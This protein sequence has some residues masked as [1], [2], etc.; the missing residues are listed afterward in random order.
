MIDLTTLITL[1]LMVIG[2]MLILIPA[3]PVSALQWTI[4][5]I[6]AALTGFQ[7]VTPAAALL[8]SLF[9]ILGATSGLWLPF[10]GLKGRNLSCLGLLAFFIGT[11]AGSFF[12]PIPILGALI[13][14]VAG[15]MMVEYAQILE[16]GQAI[17]RG[18]TAVKLIL[19]TM[20]AEFIFAVLIFATFVISV[21][22][23]A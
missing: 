18:W 11:I 12:I 2:L 9:M 3:V 19:M 5:I 4:A 14:G 21:L 16:M 20:V 7:R 6:Y 10:F 23:T 8:M 17:Q 1:I 15:V 13:G 22:S